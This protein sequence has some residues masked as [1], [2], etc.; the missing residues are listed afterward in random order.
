MSNDSE[1]GRTT[2]YY[3]DEFGRETHRRLHDGTI[4]H[5]E[6]GPSPN[7]PHP[8]KWQKVESVFEY[9]EDGFLVKEIRTTETDL[10]PSHTAEIDWKGRAWKGL[11]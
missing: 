11:S 8:T 10:T 2:T 7:G 1:I 5:F 4:E 3:Y 6:L 9:D